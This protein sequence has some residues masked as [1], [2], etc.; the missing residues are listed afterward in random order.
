MLNNEV[1]GLGISKMFT[2][3]KSLMFWY[4][5]KIVPKFVYTRRN[6]MTQEFDNVPFSHRTRG[7]K[8][9][10]ND[11]SDDEDEAVKR[12]ATAGSSK[13]YKMANSQAKKSTTEV[14][15][16]TS[17]TA[18]ESTSKNLSTHL[19]TRPLPI[20]TCKTAKMNRSSDEDFIELP[21]D[22]TEVTKENFL[23]CIYKLR[24]DLAMVKRSLEC[25]DNIKKSVKD[26][27]RSE[28]ATANG[29]IDLRKD[30]LTVKCNTEVITGDFKSFD[31]SLK[32]I[33]SGNEVRA[34]LGNI[35]YFLI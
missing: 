30:V 12:R 3:Y 29:L 1:K 27:S 4:K 32:N 26:I 18:H 23:G 6:E 13:L 7:D 34:V 28:N 15:A 9:K 22:I 21:E 35:I 8:H 5:E 19:V 20:Q 16:T 11:L 10:H 2:A 14:T 25:M 24:L 33:I 31:K 17:S